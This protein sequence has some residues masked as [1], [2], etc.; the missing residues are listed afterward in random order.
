[1]IKRQESIYK[2]SLAVI[3]EVLK[4]NNGYDYTIK[5]ESGVIIRA[6]ASLWLS[7]LKKRIAQDSVVLVKLSVNNISEGRI[8]SILN[9]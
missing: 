3:G 1:M 5:L 7:L 4:C 2:D 6:K 9:R 8:I